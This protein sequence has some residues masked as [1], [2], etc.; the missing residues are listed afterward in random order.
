[1]ADSGRNLWICFLQKRGIGPLMIYELSPK[2]H[3]DNLV[4]RCDT[5]PLMP[6][7]TCCH[8][9]D[10]LLFKFTILVI[11][12]MT[13]EKYQQWIIEGRESWTAELLSLCV[14]INQ[15]DALLR[16][17]PGCD[18]KQTAAFPACQ[19]FIWYFEYMECEYQ[20]DAFKEIAN[21]TWRAS[22]EVSLEVI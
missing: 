9:I 19:K 16:Q 22:R 2:L 13:W 12:L 6:A 18:R 15:G 14:T 4:K 1:M 20:W 7:V 21:G 3:L 8:L 10:S 5:V 17:Q 11:F